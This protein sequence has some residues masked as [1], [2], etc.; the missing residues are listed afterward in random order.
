M[1]HCV[2]L[3]ALPRRDTILHAIAEHDNGWTEGDAAPSVNPTTGK[4]FDFISAPL[5]VRQGVW[6]RAVARFAGDS[7]AAALVAQHAIAIYDRFQ[8]DP[9]WKPF[10]ADMTAVRDEMLRASGLPL[11]DLVSDYAFVRLGDLISLSFCTAGMA[12]QSFA[13]WTAECVGTRVVVTP[14][15]FGGA[16]IPIEISAKEIPDRQFYSDAELRA[17]VR[18]ANTISLRG[19]VAGSRNPE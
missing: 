7:W 2:A 16:T 14:D 15:P 17:A 4:V 13:A 18:N 8:S 5:N 1:E 9:V 19:D 12:L 3:S 11:G 6:P 10:F